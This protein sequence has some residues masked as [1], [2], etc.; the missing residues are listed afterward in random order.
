MEGEQTINQEQQTANEVPKEIQEGKFFA[1]VGYIGILCLIP[2]LL[3]KEN[4]FALFHGKQ[5]LVLLI[6]EVSAAILNIVPV[7]GQITWVIAT[8]VF[9]LLSI[10][11]ILQALMN[12]YWKMPVVGD[13]AEKI[14]L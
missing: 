8:V 10:A 5:A 6:G 9:G 14:S 3:K 12:N 4:K 2:L 1:V 7:L 11:G 13:V